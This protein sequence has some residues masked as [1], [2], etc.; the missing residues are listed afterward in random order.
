[1]GIVGFDSQA[2]QARLQLLEGGLRIGRG[3]R[4]GLAV[5]DRRVS[6]GLGSIIDRFGLLRF[7]AG[8]LRVVGGLAGLHASAAGVAG[9]VGIFGPLGTIGPVGTPGAFGFG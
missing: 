4:G 5:Q 3:L 8:V 9:A 7:V 1:L 2:F 6:D